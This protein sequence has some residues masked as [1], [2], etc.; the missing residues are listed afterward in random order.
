MAAAQAL[1]APGTN[2]NSSKPP[3]FGTGSRATPR[4]RGSC[5]GCA[6]SKVRCPGEKPT[7]SRCVKR[8]IACEY[9]ATKR[10][11]RRHDSFDGH[12]GQS[13]ETSHIRHRNRSSSIIDLNVS[14]TASLNAAFPAAP[15]AT[16]TAD[17]SR[18]LPTLSSWF[19]PNTT[20]ATTTSLGASFQPPPRGL[21]TEDSLEP[22]TSADASQ[23]SRRLL[24]PDRHDS[25]TFS[26]AEG[27]DADMT[28]DDTFDFGSNLDNT[29]C[30]NEMSFSLTLSPGDLLEE[31]LWTGVDN[32]IF[33]APPPSSDVPANTPKPS[34]LVN[35][36]NDQVTTDKDSHCNCLAHALVLMRQLFF[37]PSTTCTRSG[38]E[39]SG[40][41]D[42]LLPTVPVI[43]E[44]NRHTTEGVSAM[45]ECPCSQ[46][47][48]LL[49]VMA[50]IVFKA[51]WWYA[52]AA[53]NTPTTNTSSKDDGSIDLD[54]C[55][56]RRSSSARPSTAA[57]STPS[58]RVGSY[59]LDGD[60]SGRMAAQLVLSE[61]HRVQ[62]LVRK[63]TAT[64]KAQVVA[65][66][67]TEV[68]DSSRGN[69]AVQQPFLSLSG[70]ILDLLGVDLTR[71][72]KVLSVEIIKSLRND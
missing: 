64:L 46:D 39:K 24:S 45:L 63:L 72:L 50:H 35:P 26:V 48:H 13:S 29:S 37:Y 57:S 66:N 58:E 65:Q 5:L 28:F 27:L 43:I 21:A 31:Y 42:P 71:Q 30:S 4:L 44:R 54:Y 3:S 52:V 49:A 25:L 1:A 10:A 33:V 11:G 2:I 8:K 18:S 53:R 7:C 47:V 14:E 62:R 36:N 32:T 6:S 20:T 56:S 16:A 68:P 60:D 41:N 15:T 34:S 61:L 23:A 19:A 9:L 17:V 51:L 22:T 38:T 70:A 69:I 12:A 59:R 67:S 55:G 40:G